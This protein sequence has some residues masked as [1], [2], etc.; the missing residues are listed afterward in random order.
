MAEVGSI[1]S[2]WIIQIGIKTTSNS[3]WE[4][5]EDVGSK[6]GIGIKVDDVVIRKWK[7]GSWVD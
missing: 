2:G 5:T 3:V 4:R 6:D 1:E 7:G